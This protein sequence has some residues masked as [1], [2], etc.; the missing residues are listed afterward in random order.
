M[1]QEA[2]EPKGGTFLIF[3]I[4]DNFDSSKLTD[5]EGSREVCGISITVGRAL[6]MGR[7]AG[8]STTM[9]RPTSALH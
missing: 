2:A 5:L 3:L 7:A 4:A 6:G 1:F 9:G 8:E